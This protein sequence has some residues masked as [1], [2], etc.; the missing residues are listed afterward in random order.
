MAQELGRI[1][2]PEAE[3]FKPERKI[4]LV[5]L[6]FAP[7]EPPADFAELLA[8]YWATADEQ[9]VRLEGRIGEVKHVY[10]EMVDKGGEEGLRLAE[11]I[12]AGAS[13]LARVRMERG[14]TFEALEDSETL[15]EAM[16]WERCLFVGLTSRRASEYV[17]NAYQEA[18]KKRYELMAKRF[19]ETL[20]QGEAGLAFLNERHRVQFPED[21]RVFFVAPP[22]LDQVHRWLRDHRE[23]AAAG[24]EPGG[25][26]KE[27]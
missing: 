2:K 4:Y 9:V 14:A 6:I 13:G 26:D 3:G 27:A 15:A 23:R 1:E 8:R 18:S 5:P 22:A 11:Q 12:S 21:I 24:D 10:M 17:A 16:D 19:D 7:A 25:E 20:K